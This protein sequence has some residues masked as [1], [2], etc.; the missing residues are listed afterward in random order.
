MHFHSLNTTVNHLVMWWIYFIIEFAHFFLLKHVEINTKNHISNKVLTDYAFATYI[1]CSSKFWEKKKKS[2]CEKVYA[3]RGK[4][5]RFYFFII[6]YP[7]NYL[8]PLGICSL[9]YSFLNRYNGWKNS[10]F[11]KLFC[12]TFSN[13][14]THTLNVLISVCSSWH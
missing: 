4:W 14:V 7:S 9:Y 11:C 6:K 3:T 10:H 8:L 13:V 5:Q 1:F 2:K 12:L